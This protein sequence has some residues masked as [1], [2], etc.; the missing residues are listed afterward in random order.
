MISTRDFTIIIPCI[1]FEDCEFTLKK[2]RE[3]YKNIKIIV[4]LNRI[5]KKNKKKKNVRFIIT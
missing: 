2:I 3:L 4:C 1:K 5:S